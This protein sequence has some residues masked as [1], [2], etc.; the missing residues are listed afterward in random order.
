MR[1]CRLQVNHTQRGGGQE[2]VDVGATL[3]VLDDSLQKGVSVKVAENGSVGHVHFAL[4][5]HQG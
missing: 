2:H 4:I 3:L 1:S 5:V